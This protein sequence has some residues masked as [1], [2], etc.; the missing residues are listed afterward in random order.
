MPIEEE[1]QG[2]KERVTKI[3]CFRVGMHAFLAEVDLTALKGRNNHWE[4]DHR[5]QSL[6]LGRGKGGG[7][8][9]VS[10]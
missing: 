3:S 6:T 5:G 9:C 1:K 8:L 4:A 7:Y 10:P 2:E